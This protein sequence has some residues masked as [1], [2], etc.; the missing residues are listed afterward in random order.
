[1]CFLFV[2]YVTFIFNGLSTEGSTP[3]PW[4]SL[5]FIIPHQSSNLGN[6]C[7][8]LE[9]SFCL[10]GFHYRTRRGRAFNARISRMEAARFNIMIN[11][12]YQRLH[13]FNFADNN[14]GGCCGFQVKQY[15]DEGMSKGL[16]AQEY[17]NKLTDFAITPLKP[18]NWIKAKFEEGLC[19]NVIIQ[20]GFGEGDLRFGGSFSD[21]FDFALPYKYGRQRLTVSLQQ[22]QQNLITFQ[23]FKSH[24][25]CRDQPWL[26]QDINFFGYRKLWEVDNP[27][28]QTISLGRIRDWEPNRN[29][30]K[31]F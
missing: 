14:F 30:T 25:I 21:H 5:E 24:Y 31:C 1:M 8:S 10:L 17:Y 18:L 11:P 29:N 2:A 7:L 6:F 27:V 4:Q 13:F 15:V 19:M 22:L 20:V 12:I 26:C 23:W 16:T 9:K 3:S 28:N